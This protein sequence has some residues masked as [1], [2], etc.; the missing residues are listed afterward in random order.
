MGLMLTIAWRNLRRHKGKSLVIG[1]ILFLG[2]LLLTIGNSVVSGMER[3]LDKSIVEGFT[4]D[5]I[6]VSSEQQDNN[7]FLSMAG[8]A[9]E[10]ITYFDTLR[11]HL[12][13]S[14]LFKKMLPVGKSFAMAIHEQGGMP[15]YVYLFGVDF[16]QWREMFPNSLE[17]LQGKYPDSTGLLM[18]I[19]G[20]E[21]LYS[22]MGIWFKVKGHE[23]DTS[24][25]NEDAKKHREHL[26]IQDDIVFMGF[27]ENNT[28]SDIR[29]DVQGISKFRALN[30]IWGF[31][32]FV[33]MD[34]YRH[35]MGQISESTP[36]DLD[37][38][39][40]ALLGSDNADLDALFGSTETPASSSNNALDLKQTE[41]ISTEG[42]YSLVLT[43]FKNGLDRK[44]S[45]DSLRHYIELHKLPLRA[46]TWQE[47]TGPIGSMS[48]L[49]KAALNVFVF[50]LFF[51]A[52]II[53]VNTMSM[54]AMERTTEIGMMRAVGAQKSFITRMFF[55]ETAFLAFVFGLLGI[56][57]GYLL[58][59]LVQQ[60][61]L[62][63]DNDV[64]Q[65]FYGGDTFYPVF[66]VGDLILTLLQISIV[67]ILASL[68]PMRAA[69]SIT[70]LDAI[71]RD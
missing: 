23:L 28:A 29:M 8:R 63:T 38:T 44:Q 43:Q 58:V 39:Q 46:L 64:L 57:T 53:I 7:V 41:K 60:A 48:L 32:L 35:C 17:I 52:I 4:G 61:G 26:V 22:H 70:P 2:A 34:S 19:G 6:L 11:P 37:A 16:V 9:V 69:K 50:F 49:I 1:S 59:L 67:T 71:S 20:I 42:L 30:R 13:N 56:A 55:A 47:A 27:N 62:T 68:Y 25:L 65:L 40:R 66:G 14:G 33:D 15:G 5:A 12:E 45:I 24:L 51:V 31:F 10:N 21:E 54:A 36:P 18:S 3:G